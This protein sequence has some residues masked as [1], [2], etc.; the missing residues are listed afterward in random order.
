MKFLV[1]LLFAGC[2]ATSVRGPDTG[3]Q[4]APKNYKGTGEVKY[5]NEGMS[6]VIESRR[7]SAFQEMYDACDGKYEILKEYEKNDSAT[8][9]GNTTY[10]NSYVYFKYKCL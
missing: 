6:F 8:S 7:E 1:I 10:G 3:S 5:L 4:Y 2:A 9:W